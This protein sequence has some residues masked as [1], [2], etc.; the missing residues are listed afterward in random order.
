MAIM[1]MTAN[2]YDENDG[3]AYVDDM[4]GDDESRC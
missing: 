1:M 3:A 2:S 4:T